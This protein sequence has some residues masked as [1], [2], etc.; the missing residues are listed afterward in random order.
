MKINFN[1]IC[2]TIVPNFFGGEKEFRGKIHSDSNNKIIMATLIPGASIGMHTHT[3][4]SEIIY[5]LSGKGKVFDGTNTEELE[6][7]DVTYCP[8]GCSHTLIN[9][10]E[11]ELKFFAVIPEHHE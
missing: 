3:K 6:A 11:E 1:E 7:G 2:E 10:G 4:N 9:V 5:I 8:Q